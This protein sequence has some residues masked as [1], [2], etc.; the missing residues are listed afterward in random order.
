MASSAQSLNF[1]IRAVNE[2]SK[3]MKDIQTDLGGVE[4]KAGDAAPKL[5]KAGQETKQLGD[6]AE[7]TH[8]PLGKMSGALGDVAKIAGGFIIAQGLMKLPGFLIGAAQAA[9]EDEQATARLHQT[10]KS[11][12]DGPL[13]EQGY[14][15]DQAT[16]AVDRRIAAALP[17]AH[18]VTSAS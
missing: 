7:K 11:F 6:A 14:S 12:I 5:N 13:N 3:A 1:A 2:A 9:A 10:L 15:F 8:G 18:F 17:A 16:A 4:K